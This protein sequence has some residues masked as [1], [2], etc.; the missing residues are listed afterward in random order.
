MIDPIEVEI[1]E[2]E[3]KIVLTLPLIPPRESKSGK[4]MV[5]ASTEGNIKTD[6]KFKGR[7]VTVGVNVYY[8]PD[9]NAPVQVEGKKSGKKKAKAEDDDCGCGCDD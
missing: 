6:A 7:E 2:K 1:N 4:T 5:I 3:K 8:K 9:P